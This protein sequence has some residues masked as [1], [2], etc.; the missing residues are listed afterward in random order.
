MLTEMGIVKYE[1]IIN[2]KAGFDRWM[3]VG[4]QQVDDDVLVQ[5][6]K[7]G[8]HHLWKTKII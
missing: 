1:K 4:G 6:L 7:F 5:E 3:V 8:K 2:A